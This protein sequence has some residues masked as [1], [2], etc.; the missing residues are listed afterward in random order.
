M[1][2]LALLLRRRRPPRRRVAPTRLAAGLAGLAAAAL[3][4][5][6]RRRG[7]STEHAPAGAALPGAAPPAAPRPAAA[8]PGTAEPLAA[9][10]AGDGTPLPEPPVLPE[11]PADPRT[12]MIPI[13]TV[14]PPPTGL[15]LTEQIQRRLS[16]DPRTAD[17]HDDLEIHVAEQTVYVRGRVP[18]TFDASSVREVVLAVPGVSA[19]DLAVD[20]ASGGSAAPT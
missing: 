17:L 19:V 2:D 14:P 5:R 1:R 7:G 15:T 4:T 8:P 3:A 11:P 20:S 18:V 6:A 12:A 16:H 13:E 10:P 9:A